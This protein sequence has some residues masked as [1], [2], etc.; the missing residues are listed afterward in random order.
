MKK[1]DK[2]FRHL[3]REDKLEQLESYGWLSSDNHDILLNH[4]LI[5]E[6]IANSLIENVIGQGTLPM[7]LLPEI[8]V[9]DQPYVVPMMVEEPSVVAAASYGAKL[10][11]NTGGF[12]TVSSQRLMIGQIVFDGVTDTE[13]LSQAIQDKEAQ[14][15]QI[16]DEAYPSIKARGGGYQK[17]EIDSFPKQQLL[18]LKVYVDTKDAMGA[19][20]LNTILEAITAHLKNEFPDKDVLMSILSNHATASVV[21]VQGEIDIKDLNKGGRDGEAVARRMERASVLAQVDIHR[22]ATHNKGVMNGIHAVVLATGNDTR[23]AEASA[24]AYASRDGQ[25]RG[26]ATWKYDQERQRLIGTIEVP[27]TL[28]IVGGGTKVLPI[29]KASLDL[30]NVKSAQ[31]LGHVVAAVGLAQNFSACRALV[32]EGIQQGHMSLQYKSLAIIVGAKGDEIAQVADALKQEDKANSAKA[33]AI[34]EQIRQDQ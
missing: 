26:I 8:I 23:G 18:S 22:A 30:L 12:K 14:I 16:A 9:D 20:M 2:G 17:I 1:L 32:S 5:D 13:S 3:S 21:K 28:A 31:E 24:H 6:D 33:K 4:P 34:L 11:N 15:H 10:V 19:N 25:Y 27:M 29:A 7:G